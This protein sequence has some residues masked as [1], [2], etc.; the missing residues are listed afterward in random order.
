MSLLLSILLISA[1]AP[2]PSPTAPDNSL[3]PVETA[4]EA[5]WARTRTSPGYTAEWFA[6]RYD[7]AAPTLREQHLGALSAAIDVY[8]I[9]PK[10]KPDSEKLWKGLSENLAPDRGLARKGNEIVWI[11][12]DNPRDLAKALELIRPERV[13]TPSQD[14]G[15]LRKEI[16]RD[17]PGLRSEAPSF[18]RFLDNFE[19]RVS[20]FPLRGVYH[21]PYYKLGRSPFNPLCQIDVWIPAARQKLSD[22][23]SRLHQIATETQT[24]LVGRG[25]AA[26]VTAANP[27]GRQTLIDL[28]KKLEYRVESPPESAK[29]KPPTPEPAPS[30]SPRSE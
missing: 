22:L 5:G 21:A 28:L 15:W 6:R 3:I 27:E 1:A 25:T 24:V 2:T 7:V 8:A 12:C 29:G 13:E 16:S 14:F 4:H 18:I 19:K 17:V 20:G 11:I 10:T 30:A 9:S 23:T 26:L